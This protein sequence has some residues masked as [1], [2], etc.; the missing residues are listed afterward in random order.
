MSEEP[1]NEEYAGE[2][3][4][5]SELEIRLTRAEAKLSTLSKEVLDFR[6]AVGRQLS[7]LVEAGNSNAVVLGAAE[8]FLNEKFPGWDAGKIEEMTRRA[9]GLKARQSLLAEASRLTSEKNLDREALS[10]LAHEIWAN[11]KGISTTLEDG[12][13]AVG[14]LLKAG[15]PIPALDVLG[16]FEKLHG[17]IPENIR[18]YAEELRKRA[19]ELRGVKAPN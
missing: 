17:E 2:P 1:K 9:E 15:K 16:E 11:A 19:E 14:L 13:V 12:V 4:E 8:D 5:A 6:I 7:K 10:K 18:N 3:R